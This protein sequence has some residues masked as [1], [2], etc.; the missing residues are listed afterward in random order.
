MKGLS[1]NH[2]QKQPLRSLA[3]IK[4]WWRHIPLDVLKLFWASGN[5]AETWA[6]LTSSNLCKSP[7]QDR[8]RKGVWCTTAP[9]KYKLRKLRPVH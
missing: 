8:K 1:N 2:T 6:V 9:C 5:D 3:D 4:V 7:K